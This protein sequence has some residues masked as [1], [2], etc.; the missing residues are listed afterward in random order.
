MSKSAELTRK[1]M[2]EP[3]RFQRVA[4]KA[5]GWIGAHRQQ[6]IL[7][8]VVALVLLVAIATVSAI[9]SSRANHAGS[10]G[11]S[12]LATVGGQISSVPL[13]GV[14]GPF[15]PSEEARQRAI[16]AEAD[17]LLVDFPASGPAK[18]ALLAKGDAHFRLGEWDRAR[19][20]YERFLAET[21][22]KDSLRFGAFEGLALV[23]ESTNDLEGAA[24]GWERLGREVPAFADR[25]DLEA[26]RVYAREGKAAEARKLLEGFADRHAG[27]FLA[28]EA[29]RRLASMGN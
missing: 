15:F 21:E 10:E 16:I 28:G 11:A 9:Q 2:K 29:S 7:L 27:S 17:R 14:R 22:G 8:G 24:H 4:T 18:L 19:Q 12:L 6:F 5:A 23:A 26:A 1:D 13:P 3:D 25:A 20:A